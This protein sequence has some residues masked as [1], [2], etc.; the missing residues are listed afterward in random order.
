MTH[1]KEIKMQGS[2]IRPVDV[3]LHLASVGYHVF[4]TYV[5]YVDGRKDVR[6]VAKWKT[7]AAGPVPSAGMIRE[8]W[9]QHP[10]AWPTIITG[11]SGMVMV[12][13]DIK[14]GVD[15]SEM[16]LACTEGLLPEHT[17]PTT[18]GGFHHLYRNTT[19][20]VVHNSESQVAPG[21]DVR[22]EMGAQFVHP[23]AWEAALL[24]PPVSE[25]DELPAVVTEFEK[26][27]HT[28][29]RAALSVGADGTTREFTEE[30]ARRFVIRFAKEP[31]LAAR[32][33]RINATLYR[34]ALVVGH[35]VPD[36]VEH[37]KAFASLLAWQTSAWVASGEK[38]DGDTRTAERTI[39]S[40]WSVETWKAT[41][42][43]P[44][45]P[46]TAQDAE[47][48]PARL[49][50]PNEFWAS[51]QTLQA[52]RTAA[53][54]AMVSPDAVLAVLMAKIAA[55]LPP[56]VRAS[57]SR[58]E[59]SLN[60]ITVPVGP[61]GAGKTQAFGVADRLLPTL[62]A[63]LADPG[64]ADGAPPGSGEGL[65]AAYYGPEDEEYEDAKGKPRTKTVM[66]QVRHN[67][68]L[69][70]DEIAGLVA[71][72]QRAGTTIMSALRTAWVGATLGQLN[73]QVETR[74]I[75]RDYSFGGVFGAQ[76]LAVAPLLEDTDTGTAQRLLFAW[77]L[78]PSIPEESPGSGVIVLADVARFIAHLGTETLVIPGEADNELRRLHL[79][80]QRGESDE[81]VDDNHAPLHMIKI[82]CMMALLDRRT[83]VTMDDWGLARV[84]WDQSRIVRDH[85]KALVVSDA[86]RKA[87][88]K[89]EAAARTAAA[90]AV[91]S[92][93]ALDVRTARA[94][95]E[96]AGSIRAK[97]S[98]AGGRMGRSALAKS[99]AAGRRRH[100]ADALAHGEAEG[101]FHLEPAERSG[102]VVVI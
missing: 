56:T 61:S 45:A 82:A 34:A 93:E 25:L 91:A 22:G 9:A 64:Y 20:V 65:A 42:G 85:V 80:R 33:G 74:R 29:E 96:L 79:A 43:N 81:P 38:D 51:R 86:V 10:T 37:D 14:P 7:V 46:E 58:G 69:F 83:E 94:V 28:I 32:K 12:D 95:V 63:L 102:E 67:A 87:N 54:R 66:R 27:R 31:L 24:L 30:Q 21:V 89:I 55:M 100:M 41:L 1:D 71:T 8:W 52:V 75:V 90:S 92:S 36:F 50:L 88:A 68:F 76:V 2:T 13:C 11:M 77:A 101:W 16:W 48:R 44:T 99:V 18:S 72:G 57:T 3:A 84:V 60:M 26:T 53:H 19:D 6:P 35:F 40:A 98:A 78:D 70:C 47:E 97:V 4:P 5:R 23:C 49:N 59:A 39:R 62:P 15:G 73:A 17:L